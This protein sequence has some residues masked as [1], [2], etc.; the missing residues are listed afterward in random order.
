MARVRANAA[1][2]RLR[3]KGAVKI[4]LIN[5]DTAYSPFGA[6]GAS[7]VAWTVIGTLPVVQC[8]EVERTGNFLTGIHLKLLSI[9]API[10]NEDDCPI[11]RGRNRAPRGC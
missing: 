6:T 3:R 7:R 10:D 8:V 4:L 5:S 9:S 2:P 11:D 1:S